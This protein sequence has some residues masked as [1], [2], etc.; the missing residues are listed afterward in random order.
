MEEHLLTKTFIGPSGYS[1]TIREENGEDE[2]VLSNQADAINLMNIT[3]FISRIVIATDFTERGKLSIEDTLNLPIRDRY[4][5]LIQIRRFSLGDSLD[6]AYTWPLESTPTYYEQDLSEFV[7]DDYSKVD[8]KALESK[9]EAIK[10]YEDLEL[11]KAL[12]FKGYEVTLSTGKH[13]KFN[14]MDGNAESW[15][16]QLAPENQTRNMELLARGLQLEVNGKWDNVQQFSL[17]TVKEMAEMR[18]IVHRIDPIWPGTTEIENPR[19]HE[20][21][22]FPILGAPHFFFPAEA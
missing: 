1:Y 22:Q 11:L 18:S 15:A 19:T 21:D 16:M 7:F 14:L 13:I 6:F 2:E 20:K 10:P 9:P 3:K 5:I 12:K 4:V 8:E 17:F